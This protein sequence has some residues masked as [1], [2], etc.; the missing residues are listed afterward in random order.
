[1]KNAEKIFI[2]VLWVVAIILA[3]YLVYPSLFVKQEIKQVSTTPTIPINYSNFEK[4]IAKNGMVKAIPKDSEILLRFYNFSGGER[5]WERSFLL[6]TAS[7]KQSDRTSADITLV[8][9]SKYLNELTN[10]NLC[11]II[12]KANK[13]GDLGVETELSST[14]LLWKFK[15]MSS[16]KECL[17]L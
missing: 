5:Q 17:G 1:M 6:K 11:S 12:Q 7:V 4:E 3:V 9:A 2:G 13:N 14:S 8:L 16:Y 10:K 15:S